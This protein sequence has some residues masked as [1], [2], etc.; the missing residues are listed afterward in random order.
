M[1]RR[2]EMVARGSDGAVRCGELLPA[3]LDV[4]LDPADLGFTTTAELEPLEEVVGQERAR[5]ALE[6]GLAVRQRGYNVYV[7]GVSGTGKKQLVKQLLEKRARREATP[8]DWVYLH[9]F[10]SPDNPLAQRLPAGHGVRLR[11]AVEDIIE[12]L[13]HDLPQALKAKDFGAERERLSTAY[14]QRSEALFNELVER[15]HA[16]NFAVRRSPEGP[17]VFMPLREGR[18]MEPDEFARLPEDERAEVRKHEPELEE[19][20]GEML[21][22]QQELSRQLRSEVCEI[23]RAFARRILEPFLT[24]ARADHPQERILAWLDR[25]R[26]FLLDNLAC[27]QENGEEAKDLPAALRAAMGPED[28]W[29]PCR[30][31]VVV[32]HSGTQGAPVIVETS[33]NY[34]NLFGTIERDVNLFGHVTT[35]FTRIKPGNVLRASGGYLVFDLQDALTEPLVWKQLKRV[36]KS[37]QLHTDAYEPFAMLSTAALNPEPIPLDTKLVVLGTPGLYYELQFLDEEFS[38]LFKVRADFGPEAARDPAGHAAYAR[39]VARVA[40]DEGLPAFDGG[41]VAEVVRFGVRAAGHRDKLSVEFGRVADLVREAAYRARGDDATAVT[42][43]HVRRALDERVYRSG[44]V[45]DKVRELIAEGTLRVSLTGKRVGQVNGLSLIDLGDCCFA[46]PSRLTASVGV[47]LEGLVSIE[48]ASD[49]SGSLHDKGVLILQGYLRNRYARRHP[50]AL[51]ASLTF[52]QSYGWVEG[53]SASSAELYCLLSALADVPLRQDIAVTG[54]VDQHGDVQAVGAVNEKIEGFFDV[55]RLTELT[56]TQGVCI[57]RANARHLVLRSDVV[58]AVRE[59]RFHVWAVGTIDEGIELLT[60]MPA[61]DPDSQRTFHHGLDQ[62][63]REF[64]DIL[65]EQPTPAVVAR[66]HTAL[67]AHPRPAPPP[68]PG[69]GD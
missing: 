2:P 52:E 26:D 59:G 24:G 13:G 39:F 30:V 60:G 37:G 40:R 50:L 51:S 69:E 62:R 34:K 54:S 8:G 7:S 38:E 66:E 28:P 32:D 9:N 63:L 61:G 56:G 6:L 43:A 29:L 12:R 36:L 10:D 64:L 16:L 5:R 48:R 20:T 1:N 31:N 33:P 67:P 18:P 49:L 23:V 47:G 21:A 46:R 11:T 19:L 57:P 55:C 42:A 25:V 68:L 14:G 27:F 3:D 22:K 15:A 35:D 58:D 53:D 41:A 65:Q 4:P 17:F 44:R 45:A